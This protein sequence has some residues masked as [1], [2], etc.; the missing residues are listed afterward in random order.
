MRIAI[1]RETHPG[2]NRVPVTPETAKKL[3]RL[4]ADLVIESGMGL[5]SGFADEEYVEAGATVGAD[6]E[7]LFREADMLL[8]LRK[9]EKADIALM[10]KGCIHISYLDPFN[11]HD[12]VRTLQQQGVTAISMEMIP[13][14]TRSQKMDALSSQANLA[15]YVMVMQAATHLPR[16][17]PMMMT[18]AGTLKPAKV[19]II[20][21]GVAGLQAIAT[22]K[23]LGARVT[24]FDTRPVVAEQVQSL[25]ATFLD[26]D[27]GQTGETSGG[28][29]TE[30]TPEQIQK[31]RDAQKET[32]ADSDVVITTAQVFGRKAPVII[33][34]DMVEAMKPGSV[35]VDMAAE[36][37]G[38]VEGSVPNEVVTVNGVT[39]IGKGNLP[40]EVCRDA[41]HMYASNLFN[42]V[43][44]AWDKESN[45]FKIDFEHD[46]LPGCIITHGGEV[47][48][49]TIKNILEGGN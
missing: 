45:A 37:G 49:E 18:P 17:F 47:T 46:I 36:T 23:R 38:N 42:L 33:T 12:L 1:P 39:I 2:E 3:C 5:G 30:L 9:P 16:I 21:A 26:I 20:G 4:G 13:R 44:D 35:I 11:E 22:A 10:K 24:A 43:D 14:T 15:G 31:Q 19:F 32:I 29:A 6:R 7:A 25:G 48:N 8:R 27:L 40:N 41:S 34:K 28:Y